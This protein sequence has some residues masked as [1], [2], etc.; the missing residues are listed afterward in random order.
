MKCQ[1]HVLEKSDAEMQRKEKMLVALIANSFL[2]L[3]IIAR[4]RRTRNITYGR[5][6]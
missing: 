1:L 5:I 4:A 3:E 2:D 6:S